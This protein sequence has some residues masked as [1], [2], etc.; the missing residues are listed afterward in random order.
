M[1]IS[2]LV[3][4]ADLSRTRRAKEQR[5]DYLLFPTDN[6][7]EWTIISRAGQN[8]TVTEAGSCSCPDSVHRLKGETLCKHGHLLISHLASLAAQGVFFCPTCGSGFTGDSC[9][10]CRLRELE[11]LAPVRGN[12]RRLWE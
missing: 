2:E 10:E 7:G 3:T 8:Y 11:A 12:D 9:G 1:S 5:N 4:P 6:A